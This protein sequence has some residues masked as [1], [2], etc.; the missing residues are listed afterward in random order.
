MFSALIGIFFLVSVAILVARCNVTDPFSA[1]TDLFGENAGLAALT[2][3]FTCWDTELR[4][5]PYS[6]SG[7]CAE[8]GMDDVFSGIH[9][10]MAGS[11]AAE[12]SFWIRKNTLTFGDLELLWGKAEIE[13]HCEMVVASWPERHIMAF[14]A[15]SQTKHITYFLPVV[16]VAFVLSDLPQWWQLALTNDVFQNCGIE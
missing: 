12:I 7:Y 4:D 14:A 8:S 3:G 6:S 16:S 9:L 5:Q 2:H 11:K 15:P 1:Y 10:R 13:R